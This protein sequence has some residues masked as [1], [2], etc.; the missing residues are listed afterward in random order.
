MELSKQLSHLLV[1]LQMLGI[2]GLRY[3]RTKNTLHVSYTFVIINVIT[4]ASFWLVNLTYML[5]GPR[6][7][8]TNNCSGYFYLNIFEMLFSMITLTTSLDMIRHVDLF[9]VSLSI[10]QEVDTYLKKH[11]VV[12]NRRPPYHLAL[13]CASILTVMFVL[14]VTSTLRLNVAFNIFVIYWPIGLMNIR[15]WFITSIISLMRRR[16]QALLDMLSDNLYRKRRYLLD[17]L[18]R[19]HEMLCR[20]C[21][22]IN[23]VFSL[24]MLVMT[25]SLYYMIIT[26]S[27][28]M[29]CYLGW[30]TKSVIKALAVVMFAL[31][32]KQEI[33]ECTKVSWKV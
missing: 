20:S 33:D 30:E 7:A 16:Y 3:I 31:I 22:Y 19:N 29:L 26:E 15:I 10:V 14:R 24:P 1:P 17:D 18:I 2:C 12:I 9:N 8:I 28:V 11:S 23:S 5:G 4:V 21:E 27:Y 25:F 13:S 32:I 6:R